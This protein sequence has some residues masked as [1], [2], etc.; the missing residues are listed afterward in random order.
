MELEFAE[1]VRAV[2]DHPVDSSRS[3]RRRHPFRNREI[4]FG[5]IEFIAKL[6]DDPV[7]CLSGFSDDQVAQ[8][9]FRSGGSHRV[10]TSN[11]ATTRWRSTT[12]EGAR[13]WPCEEV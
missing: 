6:F 12:L 11:G 10:A 5:D 13:H 1:W 9:L 2:F 4:G 3:A 8:G 7:Q